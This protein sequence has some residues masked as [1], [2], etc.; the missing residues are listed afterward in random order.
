MTWIDLPNL[1]T[2]TIGDGSFAYSE[3]FSIDN[4]D[5][6]TYIYVGNHCFYSVKEFRLIGFN[7]LRHLIIGNNS[8]TQQIESYGND[9][10]KSFYII[11][12]TMLITIQ[13]GS[14]SFSD[15]AG[16]FVLHNLPALE[17]IVIGRVNYISYNF[18][19]SSFVIYSKNHLF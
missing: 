3:H 19:F 15:F 7:H 13:I 2:I 17:V 6:V 4:A 5:S 1:E 18:Y 11:N 8:F 10:S 9:T 16:E 12:C 14:F